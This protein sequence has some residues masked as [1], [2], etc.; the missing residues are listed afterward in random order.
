MTLLSVAVSRQKGRSRVNKCFMADMQETLKQVKKFKHLGITLESDCRQNKNW[1]FK[2]EKNKYSS[3]MR[4]LQR[5]LD[6]K[7][8][9]SRH[10]KL[11]FFKPL[12]VSILRPHSYVHESWK[13]IGRVRFRV[14]ATAVLTK[15]TKQF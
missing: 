11:S 1:T 14:Q 12:F 13:M 9:L 15:H 7:G 10:A 8:H 5:S 6:V 2:P 3:V 4:E